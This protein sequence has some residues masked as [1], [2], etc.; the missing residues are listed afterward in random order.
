MRIT[1]HIASKVRA[2]QR[3]ARVRMPNALSVSVPVMH[4]TLSHTE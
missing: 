2:D 3:D 4:D 1:Q